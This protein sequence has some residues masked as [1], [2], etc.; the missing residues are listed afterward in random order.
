MA[1]VAVMVSFAKKLEQCWYSSPPLVLLP[2][3]GFYRSV[4]SIR[5]W[6]YKCGLLSSECLGVPV[7]IV[8]NINVG[9][10][11]KT[12]LTI[13]LARL[14]RDVGF[15]PG[16][17]TR[18]YGG[19]AQHWPQLV[20]PGSDPVMVGDE[21]VILAERSDCPVMAGPDRVD[22][23]QRLINE[24]GCNLIMS[25][26]GLQH[27]RLN[28]SIEIVVVDGERR[29]GNGHC[30]PVGPLREPLK[31]LADVDFIVVNGVTE[32]KNEYG[33]QLKATQLCAVSNS[34]TISIE[35]CRGKS[36]HAVAGIG[37]PDRFFSQLRNF[38][39]NVIEHPFEDHHLF[40]SQDLNFGDDLLVLMTEKDAV[41]CRAF[42]DDRH[43]YLP[44]DACIDD[45]F[46]IKLLDKIGVDVN[47]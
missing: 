8:G 25:D 41:K 40:S 28:R 42:A 47:G 33:M 35:S 37:N 39:L 27:Y 12:P 26:D 17:I 5:R 38:G 46:G 30:L 11:G 6:A 21:P 2:V 10:T 22:S 45:D 1:C 34:K 13:Y 43:W 24:H 9:G 31:R 32:N 20:Q 7:V 19:Q 36:V 16:I 29:F 23:A 4:V 18:G 3:E 14:L 44:V 15:R